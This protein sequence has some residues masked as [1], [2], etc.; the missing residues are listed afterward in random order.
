MGESVK[1]TSESVSSDSSFAALVSDELESI[2]VHSL[3]RFNTSS[4][5]RHLVDHKL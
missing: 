4:I 3:S 2:E 1:L 5:G